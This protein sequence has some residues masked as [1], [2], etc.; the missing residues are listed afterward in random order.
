VNRVQVVR[1][2]GLGAINAAVLTSYYI[3]WSASSATSKEGVQR[4]DTRA[5]RLKVSFDHLETGVEE[6]VL[7]HV[8][9]ERIGFQGYGMM[10]AEIGLPPGVDVDRNSLEL[11]RQGAG[12]MSYEVQ[13]DRVVFYVWPQAGGTQFTFG[14]RPRY[15]MEAMTT[16]SVIYDYYNPDAR[17]TVAPV[18]FTVR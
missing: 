13:P 5:L 9:T 14:F 3:P 2:G 4:G 10:M 17:A 6:L 11:A 8:E 18:R 1:E 16:Q 12:V 15:R 7:C